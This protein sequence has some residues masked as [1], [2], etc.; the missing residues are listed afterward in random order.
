VPWWGGSGCSGVVE[1]FDLFDT[2]KSKITTH[3]ISMPLPYYH[4]AQ[5]PPGPLPQ[6]R[7]QPVGGAFTHGPRAHGGGDSVCVLPRRCLRHTLTRPQTQPH[8]H[9]S[10][11]HPATQHSNLP[12]YHTP[13]PHSH[14]YVGY[15]LPAPG[16]SLRP[17]LVSVHFKNRANLHA[18][19]PLK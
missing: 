18:R 9:T 17:G 7:P 12:P 2:G 10:P 19:K 8:T 15:K 3:P 14:L 4:L 16:V 5:H 1:L 11:F 13:A 6:G